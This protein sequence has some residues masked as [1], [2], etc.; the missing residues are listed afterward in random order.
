MRGCNSTS[1]GDFWDAWDTFLKPIDMREIKESLILY[2]LHILIGSE[3]PSLASLAPP[4][5]A[6]HTPLARSGRSPL[7]FPPQPN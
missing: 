2:F 5:G 3:K 4:A 6:L 7:V 1:S